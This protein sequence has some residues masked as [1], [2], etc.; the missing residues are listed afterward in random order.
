[1]VRTLVGTMFEVAQGKRTLDDLRVLLE[2]GPRDEAGITA[3]PHGLFLW[4]VRYA[5]GQKPSISAQAPAPD[6]HDG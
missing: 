6:E 4:D 2:G 3:P 5:R 1:M